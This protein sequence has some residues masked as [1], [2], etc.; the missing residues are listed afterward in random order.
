MWMPFGKH[1]G[2]ALGE[3]PTPYLRWLL[4]IDLDPSLRWDVERELSARRSSPAP[5][6]PPGIDPAALSAA[7]R[8]WKRD[9]VLRHHPDRGGRHEAM[10]A[11][12][13][14][15]DRLTEAMNRKGIPCDA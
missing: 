13:D 14:A 2:R 15:F 3:I 1:Q 12:N 7:I 5:P 4:T 9:L 10:T 8:E 6:T 11:L